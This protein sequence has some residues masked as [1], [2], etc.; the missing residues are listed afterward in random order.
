MDV[1]YRARRAT[2]PRRPPSRSQAI[3]HAW[4]ITPSSEFRNEAAACLALPAI[5]KMETTQIA[6]PDSTCS[7]DGSYAASFSGNDVV[8]RE[9]SNNQEVARLPNQ[10]PDSLLKLDDHGSRILEIDHFT[11]LLRLTPPSHAG[12]VGECHLVFDA[13]ASH[14]LVH[15]ALGCVMCW[16]LTQLEQ[17]LIGLGMKR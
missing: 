2:S 17:E 15:T 13:D 5:G 10:Q 3:Q 6:A 8:V 11:E 4:A 9:I 16:D 12:W 1:V 14:L 7:A